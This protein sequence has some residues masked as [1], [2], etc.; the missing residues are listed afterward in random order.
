[1]KKDKSKLKFQFLIVMTFVLFFFITCEDSKQDRFPD[2]GHDGP[3]VEN[4]IYFGH[5]NYIEYHAGTLPIILSASH[6]GWM[7]PTEIA[8]RTQG[9]TAI[10]TKTMVVV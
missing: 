1:M 2:L 8:D 6:G 9:V 4:S 10:D 5:G 3:Y 7:E